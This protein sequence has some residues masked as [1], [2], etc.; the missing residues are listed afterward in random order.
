MAK[1]LYV[2]NLSYSTTEDTLRD[3]FAEFGQ[4]SSV[5]IISDRATGRPKGF[6]FVEMAD[7]AAAQQAINALNGREVDGRAIRV[8]EAKPREEGRFGDRGGGDRG[9]DRGRDRDSGPRR[10]W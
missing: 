2:G 7:N 8:S 10:R 5:D 3:L 6:G 4:V 1:K 9:G